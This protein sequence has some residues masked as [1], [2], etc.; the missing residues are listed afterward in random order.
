[1]Q[2][3]GVRAVKSL[4]DEQEVLPGL[5][6]LLEHG[7]QGGEL[8][9]ALAHVFL[10][11]DGAHPGAIPSAAAL[12]QA[13]PFSVLYGLPPL[14]LPQAALKTRVVVSSNTKGSSRIQQAQKL[15]AGFW[16]VPLA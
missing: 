5:A 14:T 13:R 11:I 8:L 2:E 4:G 12:L 15:P 6:K 10:W 3:V 7:R 1:M 9:A 16:A